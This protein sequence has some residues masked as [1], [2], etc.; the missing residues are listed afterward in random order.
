MCELGVYYV[1]DY[2]VGLFELVC[3]VVLD[4]VDYVMSLIYIE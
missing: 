2:C 1:V 3:V 4:G